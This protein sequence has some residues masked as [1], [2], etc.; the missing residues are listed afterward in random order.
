MSKSVHT[1]GQHM[2]KVTHCLLYY[3]NCYKVMTFSLQLV[4]HIRLL[5]VSTDTSYVA[6]CMVSQLAC[7]VMM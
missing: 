1:R 7:F 6:L 3:M 2:S 4:T 5:S